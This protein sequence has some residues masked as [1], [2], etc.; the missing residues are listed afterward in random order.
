MHGLLVSSPAFLARGPQSA[1]FFFA[2]MGYDVWMTNARGNMHSRNHTSLNPDETEF[3]DFSWHEI[4]L[5]DLPATIDYILRRT[6]QTKLDY[7]GHSQGVTVA[8]AMLCLLPQYN[9]KNNTLHAMAPPIIMKHLHPVIAVF[10]Q[11]NDLVLIEV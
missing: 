4:G 9:R 7:I 6:N 2:D 5:Y 8:I 10:L 1:G 3:W 11:I